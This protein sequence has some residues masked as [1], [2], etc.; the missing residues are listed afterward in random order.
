M[1]LHETPLGDLMETCYPYRAG[2][3][4]FPSRRGEGPMACLMQPKSRHRRETTGRARQVT[5]FRK[6]ALVTSTPRIV[7]K[8]RD[9]GYPAQ[10]EYDWPAWIRTR[11]TQNQ[12]LVRYQLRHG[13]KKSESGMVTR[14]AV[15]DKDWTGVAALKHERPSL[16]RPGTRN[17]ENRRGARKATDCPPGKGSC[18]LWWAILNKFERKRREGG[19]PPVWRLSFQARERGSPI[20]AEVGMAR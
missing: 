10:E 14:K 3:L 1:A 4:F 13:P 6:I 15:C 16:G 5:S 12:N 17:G 2:P 8:K 7:T 18:E 11:N 9:T 19:H 20:R